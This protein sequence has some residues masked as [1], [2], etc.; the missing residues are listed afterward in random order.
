M[1]LQLTEVMV[2]LKVLLVQAFIGMFE[3]VVL[4]LDALDL[5]FEVSELRVEVLALNVRFL[6]SLIRLH[7]LR[8]LLLSHPFGG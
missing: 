7:Y 1:L 8:V 6:K 5:L 4:S 3:L 2:F